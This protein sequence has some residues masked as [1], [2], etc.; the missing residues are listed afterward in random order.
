MYINLLLRE[1]GR[2]P[3]ASVK[4]RAMDGC[5][6]SVIQNEISVI[7]LR[8]IQKYSDPKHLF[9]WTQNLS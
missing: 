6:I 3:C 9:L 4:M 8:R 1:F 5:E 7:Y 2:K